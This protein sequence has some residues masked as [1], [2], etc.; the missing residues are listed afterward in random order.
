[1]CYNCGCRKPDDDHG[2]PSNI[3]NQTFERAARA[4]DQATED[5]RTETMKL[6][7]DVDL[8]SGTLV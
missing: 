4:M 1:M 5:A 3:T 7:Q 8:P 2:D 6:L